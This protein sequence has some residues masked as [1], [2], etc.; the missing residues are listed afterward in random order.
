MFYQP[1]GPENTVPSDPE[2]IS[3][4]ITTR[5]NLDCVMCPHGLPNGMLI[6]KDASDT[7]IDSLLATIDEV[8]YWHPIGTGEP[9]L[10]RG[11]WRII[12]ALEGRSSPGV[13]MNTNGV[14]LTRQNV[15]RLVKAP[16]QHVN[17]SMDAA[18]PET[19]KKIRGFDLRKVVD[20]A[21]RLADAFARTP[22]PA[23]NML[24][25]SMVL[26][27]ENIEELP[28]FVLLA[29]DIGAH[30]VYVEQLL[31]PTTPIEQWV[32]RR[33]DFEFRYQDQRLSG[34]PDLNDK[35]VM[36][37]LNLADELDIKLS[38]PELFY[39]QDQSAANQRPCRVV[40]YGH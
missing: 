23:G 34:Y 5:C 15:E 28:G 29:K 24:F 36:Q 12:D 14:L 30:G 22:T 33:D 16:I 21:R 13:V 6:K 26:M 11:F 32:V 3:L 40:A 27:R 17:V 2:Q 20:G 31:P 25:I 4:E 39:K 7:L 18:L 8:K 38:G 19:Y 37:A 10:A 1:Y 35:Y 9:L